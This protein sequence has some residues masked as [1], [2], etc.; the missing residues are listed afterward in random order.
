MGVQEQGVVRV[1][2]TYVY[3]CVSLEQSK[4]RQEGSKESRLMSLPKQYTIY[5]V[6]FEFYKF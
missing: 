4:S 1:T 6:S 2:E 3:M 5:K